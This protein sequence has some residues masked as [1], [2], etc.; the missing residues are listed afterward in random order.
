MVSP[1]TVA[2]YSKSL[3]R[4]GWV[5]DAKTL[6]VTPRHNLQ[7]TASLTVAADHPRA[8]DL[9]EPGARLVVEFDG[10]QILSGPL[11]RRGGEVR[12]DADITVD[13]RDDW[14]L[15]RSL[16]G[17][18]NPTGTLAQQGDD[19]AYRTVTGP[20]ETVVKTLVAENVGRTGLPVTIAPDLGRGDTITV[21]VRMHPLADRLLPLIDQAGIGVTVRQV[22]P[23]TQGTGLQVD[24]YT[25]AQYPRTLTDASG[26][27]VGGSWSL[28]AP[29]V[30]R[31]VVGGPG[32][33]VDRVFVEV[34]DTAAEAEWG[35]VL[36]Q[37]ADARDVTEGPD[38]AV[39]LEQRGWERLAEAKAKAGL[40]VSLSET[41]TFRVHPSGLWVGTR[42]RLDVGTVV[43]EDVLREA[44]MSF[45]RDNGFQATPLVGERS[46]D[47]SVSLARAVAGIARGLRR[48]TSER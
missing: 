35:L 5:G 37:F 9:L 2:V 1:L 44:P 23:K 11:T 47:P 34:V 48:L 27:V 16:L 15:L 33:G 8:G 26:V 36:E 6:L 28:T 17:R 19:G 18:P 3:K 32:E 13:V 46:D 14:H 4:L 12:P 7:S 22:G 39:R 40:A 10:E 42:V 24:C 45:T 25:P 41:S 38:L 31:V 29:E 21:Q 30:T 20:A 43:V